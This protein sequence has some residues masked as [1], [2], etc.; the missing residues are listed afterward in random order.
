MRG[1]FL[2]AKLLVNGDYQEF[3]ENVLKTRSH[4]PRKPL[5]AQSQVENAVLM[6]TVFIV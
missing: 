5:Q 3:E 6:G 2:H 1:C 4:N